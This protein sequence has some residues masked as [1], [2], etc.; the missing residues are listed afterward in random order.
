MSALRLASS[1]SSQSPVEACSGLRPRLLSMA[2][3]K[4]TNWPLI[5]AQHCV[6]SCAMPHDLGLSRQTHAC[7]L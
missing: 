5:A 6:S 3:T 1:C 4:G 2:S 7:A